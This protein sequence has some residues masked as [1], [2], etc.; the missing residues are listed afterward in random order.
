[1]SS[2]SSTMQGSGH[3]TTAE[4]SIS[5]GGSG[6][7]SP[8]SPGY[9]VDQE[10]NIQLQGLKVLHVEGLTK[11]QLRDT[12][13]LRLDEKYGGP[14]RNP[15]YTIRFVNYHFTMLGAV[16]RPGVFSISGKHVHLFEGVGIAGSMTFYCRRV[17]LLI[18]PGK[19]R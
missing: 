7:G 5:S 19:N 3:G 9:L 14:L 10:G 17:K 12:L 6:S 1:M 4:T 8:S 11:Q 16:T 15:Y 18:I 13:D 2:S